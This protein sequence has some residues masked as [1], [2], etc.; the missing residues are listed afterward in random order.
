MFQLKCCRY[1]S[2]QYSHKMKLWARARARACHAMPERFIRIKGQWPYRSA[3][4]NCF[5]ILWSSCDVS[6]QVLGRRWRSRS[7]RKSAPTWAKRGR[8]AISSAAP[9][10]GRWSGSSP[11]F[12]RS[13]S[14]KFFGN[15][16]SGIPISKFYRAQHPR[17]N[18]AGS[19]HRSS[20]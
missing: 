11:E 9:Q 17:C 20:R 15:L 1:L 6:C 13:L 7:G 8:N 3:C 2:T 19:C 14:E 12:D 16:T 5:E 4:I 10:R 18:Y